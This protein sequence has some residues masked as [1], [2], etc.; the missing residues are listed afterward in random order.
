MEELS[1]IVPRALKNHIRRE[2]GP[3]LAVISG[4]WL[5]VAGRAI[6][7]QARPAAFSAGVL[8]L[9]AASDCWVV[10]LQGLSGEIC[11]AVNRALGQP[12]VKQLRVRLAWKSAQ[13]ASDASAT[14]APAG[15]PVISLDRLQMESDSTSGPQASLDAE[16]RNIV[17]L[18]VAKYFARPN[19]P[20]GRLN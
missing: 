16:I 18:S 7:E 9:T 3:L 1:R 6:A 17:A 5:R 10:Q 2:K 19:G 4:M 14:P 13:E 8:T 20:K 11:A 12:L 15:P